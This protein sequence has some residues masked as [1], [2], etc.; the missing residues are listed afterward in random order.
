MRANDGPFPIKCPDCS[1]GTT[2][3]QSA[4]RGLVTRSIL[5][6]LANAEVI[7]VITAQR[8]LLQ[9]VNHVAN[10]AEIDFLYSLSKLC[11]NCSTP[12]V[13]YKGHG[14][15]H[16]MPGSGCPACHCHFCYQCLSFY[17]PG[18]PWGGCPLGCSLFCDEH[19]DCPTCLDCLSLGEPCSVCDGRNRACPACNEN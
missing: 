15:H 17:P 12:I 9:Q 7:N 19:C 5:K 8:I 10:E 1:S 13:H 6:G 4:D 11:P 2:P 14:C 3:T 18:T 16:I